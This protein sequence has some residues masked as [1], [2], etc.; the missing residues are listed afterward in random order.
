MELA[1]DLLPPIP[2]GSA[3]LPEDS[4]METNIEVNESPE[5][6]GSNVSRNL[7]VSQIKLQAI[8]MK[9]LKIPVWDSPDDP[10]PDPKITIQ[11][12]FHHTFTLSVEDILKYNVRCPQCRVG[13]DEIAKKIYES[14]DEKLFK[15]VRI[16]RYG[17]LVL[18]CVEN[19]HKIRMSYDVKSDE[20]DVPGYCPECVVESN[21]PSHSVT[22][23]DE[24]DLA[25]Q[26]EALNLGKGLGEGESDDDWESYFKYDDFLHHGGEVDMKDVFEDENPHDENAFNNFDFDLFEFP[27]TG[28]EV[29]TGSDLDQHKP[30]C[31]SEYEN[32]FDSVSMSDTDQPKKEMSLEEEVQKEFEDPQINHIVATIISRNYI[33]YASQKETA[34]ANYNSKF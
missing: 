5:S 22:L 17:Q 25:E 8:L 3:I 6:T 23:M 19:N 20:N 34:L 12:N 21:S 27:G 2:N 31:S 28:Y 10:E 15:V 9:H 13:L 33:T 24:A 11:C 4:K 26:L 1:N 29:D 7:S 30:C 14:L 18:R 32:Y 16:N